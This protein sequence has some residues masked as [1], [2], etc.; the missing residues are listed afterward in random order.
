[1]NTIGSY[2]KDT[3]KEI[4]VRIDL[5]KFMSNWRDIL[6]RHPISGEDD[7]ELKRR[8]KNHEKE[9]E[10]DGTSYFAKLHDSAT[11]FATERGILTF[12]QDTA[13]D[14]SYMSSPAWVKRYL[15]IK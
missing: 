6:G 9:K 1:M 13:T 5:R 10:K 7:P 11:N 8:V 4:Q 14:V 3:L 2:D 12:S 15:K